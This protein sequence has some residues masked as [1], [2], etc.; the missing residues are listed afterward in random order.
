MADKPTSYDRYMELVEKARTV[1]G[2]SNG[3]II[4]GLREEAK[5]IE[6]RCR[7][8]MRELSMARSPYPAREARRAAT[9][10]IM[11]IERICNELAEQKETAQ[12]ESEPA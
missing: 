1:H 6:A 3:Q 4:I 7:D 8:K 12:C 9:E 10:C 2:H 11:V 5:R